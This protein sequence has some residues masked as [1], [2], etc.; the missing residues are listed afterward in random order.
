M[1]EPT[2]DEMRRHRAKI[3]N[4]LVALGMFITVGFA[5]MLV[6]GGLLAPLYG[7]LDAGLIRSAIMLT[8]G[9]VIV[10]AGYSLRRYFR[11][12]T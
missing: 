12:E 10:L 2:P 3:H 4:Q 11:S 8:V 5:A 6:V 9:G 7:P 1:T